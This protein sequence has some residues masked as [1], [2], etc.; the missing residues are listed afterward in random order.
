VQL[1]HKAIG[2]LFLGRVDASA[3]ARREQERAT[4]QRNA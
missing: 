3:A 2:G 4:H 1:D